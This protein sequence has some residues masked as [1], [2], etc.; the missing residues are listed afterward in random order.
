MSVN[1]RAPSFTPTSLDRYS[2]PY[3]GPKDPNGKRANDFD[4][5]ALRYLMMTG[6]T[7]PKNPATLDQT[8]AY[9]DGTPNH[10]GL[11]CMNADQFWAEWLL[12][13]LMPLNQASEVQCDTPH[14]K[15]WRDGF[16]V[17]PRVMIGTNSKH[18]DANDAYFK[19]S[20]APSPEIGP[21]FIW[22]GEELSSYGQDNAGG[23]GW[24]RVEVW[25]TCRLD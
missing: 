6:N 11:L 3:I 24:N 5:N 25:Q 16:E 23:N 14:T 20:G 13:L 9:V 19:F 12:P 8:G 15:C 21:A 22:K 2:Y 4:Q 7:T 17:A 1:R 10:E 18:K